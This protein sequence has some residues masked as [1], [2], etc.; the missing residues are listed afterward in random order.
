MRCTW[1]NVIGSSAGRM[2]VLFVAG[3]YGLVQIDAP[4]RAEEGA[5]A[6]HDAGYVVA[7]GNSD[8]GKQLF[9]GKGCVGCHSINGV[10]GKAGPT[11]DASRVGR[12][13]DIFDFA[14]RML[15]GAPLMIVLQ[16][17]EMGYRIDLSGQELADIARFI[18]D[19]EA[20]RTF[21]ESDVPELIRDWMVD[22]VYDAF[23]IEEMAN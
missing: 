9:T 5:R 4:A 19:T 10:G 7:F 14:A 3:L 12:Q 11:L 21:A 15:R 8:N 20:Q 17:M 23:E 13:L 16:E 18:H 1:R 6:N 22:E 2:A